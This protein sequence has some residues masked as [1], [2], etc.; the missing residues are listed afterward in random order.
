MNTPAV[1]GY[2]RKAIVQI[3]IEEIIERLGLPKMGDLKGEHAGCDFRL[4]GHDM[5]FK[6]WDNSLP[7]E[8]ETP[9]G[10]AILMISLQT[11]HKIKGMK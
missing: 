9:P 7:V 1:S 10:N 2:Q 6:Y 11:M 8:F 3:S 4:E 5:L